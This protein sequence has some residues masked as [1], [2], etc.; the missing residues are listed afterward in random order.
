MYYAWYI[1]A[2][3]WRFLKNRYSDLTERSLKD[4]YSY[5]ILNIL[6]ITGGI[7]AFS[8]KQMHLG[9]VY[10]IVTP[11]IHMNNSCAMQM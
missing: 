10:S 11:Q 8:S 3:Q 5:I 4:S 1:H 2:Q 6:I 7:N 9:F